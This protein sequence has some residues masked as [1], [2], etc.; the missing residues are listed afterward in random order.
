[1]QID[2][3][4]L[5]N[6]R[7]FVHLELTLDQHLTV[8]AG[9]NGAGKSSVLEGLAVALGAWLL[10]FEGASP[11]NIAP[12]Q[13]RVV[14]HIFD[15]IPTIEAQYPCRVAAVGTLGEDVISWARELRCA[16]CKTTYGEA[17]SLRALANKLQVAVR[18]GA[19]V[20]LPVIAFYGTGRLWV[21]KRANTERESRLSSRT[22]AYA[23]CLEP[24]SNQKRFEAW[25]RQQEMARVQRI[26]EHNRGV[27]P[28][29]LFRPPA[30]EAVQRAAAGM[31]EGAERLYFDVAHDELRL[32]FGNDTHLPFTLLSDGYRNLI[33]MAADLAWRA[34]QLNPHLGAKAPQRA[35]GVVLIDEI[36]LHLHPA[37]QRIVLDRLLKTFPKLQ[38]IVTT[39]APLV[40]ASVPAQRL[41]FLSPEGQVSVVS[42]GQGLSADSVLRQLMDVPERPDETI[43][44]LA[45]LGALIE[46]GDQKKARDLFNKL[47]QQL[48][49]LDPDLITLEWE[50]QDLE[51]EHASH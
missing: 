44:Q 43:R 26:A 30:L 13:V 49:K 4:T 5:K 7:S 28:P 47:R 34:V 33:A 35:R 46:G 15:S 48:G 32:I 23:D 11:H 12:D 25:M 10:G 16:A 27:L 9:V 3:L 36:E 17:V 2:T 37:W 20:D 6:F 51:V 29:H 41:R 1:M 21:Q 24:A 45:E 19:P 40:I 39:H 22:E 38:F 50:L 18:D 14:Q 31:V 8:I 42:T